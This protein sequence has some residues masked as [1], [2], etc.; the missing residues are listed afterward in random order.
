MAYQYNWTLMDES[1]TYTLDDAEEYLNELEV[2]A[3]EAWLQSGQDTALL[4]QQKALI[5]GDAYDIILEGAGLL[6]G[7]YTEYTLDPYIDP[8]TNKPRISWAW[9]EGMDTD[10]YTYIG[11]EV[12][13]SYYR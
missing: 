3:A 12:G 1:R 8:A 7:A 10:Y 5:R 6:R 9:I 2:I 11:Y 4:N 13:E